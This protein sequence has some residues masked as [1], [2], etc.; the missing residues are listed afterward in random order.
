MIQSKK[1][2][3][4]G[5]LW[6]IAIG[7][8]AFFM[9]EKHQL[10]KEIV[11]PVVEQN[12]FHAVPRSFDQFIYIKTDKDLQKVLDTQDTTLISGDFQSLLRQTDEVLLRKYSTGTRE[13]DLLFLNWSHLDR[14]ILA[15]VGLASNTSGYEL[16][17]LKQDVWVYGLSEVL[18]RYDEQKNSLLDDE[19]VQ[20]YRDDFSNGGYNMGFFSHPRVIAWLAWFERFVEKLQYVAVMT[21]LDLVHTRGKLALQFD[22]G[23]VHGT[24]AVFEPTFE[25]YKNDDTIF[26]LELHDLVW[27]LGIDKEQFMQ[28]APLVFWQGKS[29]YA[30]LLDHEDYANIYDAFHQQVGLLIDASHENPWW[31]DFW[32]FFENKNL[33]AS[34]KKLDPFW[35]DVLN[36]F[37]GTGNQEEHQ[38][39]SAIQYI[40]SPLWWSGAN[41]LQF[42]LSMYDD[43]TLLSLS[44]PWKERWATSWYSLELG[45]TYDKNTIISVEFD[46]H[47][48]QNLGQRFWWA[49]W[50]SKIWEQGI[51]EAHVK[52]DK[53]NSQVFVDF[54]V[55]KN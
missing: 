8:M 53:E 14:E 12:L 5:L 48:L 49:G 10:P 19:Q 50:W 6:L 24:D 1:Y 26:A 15:S 38:Q 36:T 16:R 31:M 35:K 43:M 33:F 17:N 18:D 4:T 44:S 25:K 27:F 21:H 3:F 54:E 7:G 2:I 34:L 13:Y 22:K 47:A 23:V 30:H 46:T 37:W 20:K 40:F 28:I 45:K 51:F 32:L 9:M 55:R 29:A 52:A 41:K 39:A 11:S 42:L